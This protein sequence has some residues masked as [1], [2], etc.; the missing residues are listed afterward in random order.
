MGVSLFH[1]W[2]LVLVLV[3]SENAAGMDTHIA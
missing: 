2:Y 3:V 1:E